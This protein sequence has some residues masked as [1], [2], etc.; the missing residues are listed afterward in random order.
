H[1]AQPVV[2]WSLDG[3]H[4]RRRGGRNAGFFQSGLPRELPRRRSEC[5][6]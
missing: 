6:I 3:G 5:G 1:P 4:P 2:F